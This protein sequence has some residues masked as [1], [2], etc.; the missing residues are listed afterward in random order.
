MVLNLTEYLQLMESLMFGKVSI[1][2]PERFVDIE[3]R[4]LNLHL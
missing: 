3:L 1:I 4:P 2:S